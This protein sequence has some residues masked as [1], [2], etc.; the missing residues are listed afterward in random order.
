MEDGNQDTRVVGFLTFPFFFYMTLHECWNIWSSSSQKPVV[1]L[2]FRQLIIGEAKQRHVQHCSGGLEGMF[3]CSFGDL[4]D[5]CVVREAE[6][7]ART[8][9]P[10]GG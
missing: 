6:Q 2:S 9:Q 1:Q 8:V 10:G 5:R 3:F 4:Q 7:P